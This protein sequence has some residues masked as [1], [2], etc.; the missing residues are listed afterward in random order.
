MKTRY[1]NFI[2]LLWFIVAA[3]TAARLAV[4]IL[5]YNTFDTFWYRDWA[6]GLQEGLFDIYTRAEQISLDYPPL[7]L[8]CLWLTGQA[9]RFFGLDCSNGMQMFLMKFWPIFFDMLCILFIYRICRRHGEW[10][11]I[12]AAAFWAFNPSVFYNTAY[13]GQT[14]QLMALLLLA[15]FVL[16]ERDRPIFACIIFAVAGLTKYQSLFFTPVLLPLIFKKYDLKRLLLGCGAAAA[17][18][19]AVFLPFMIGAREP[20]LFFKVYMGGANTYQYCTF[21]AYNLYSLLGLNTVLDSTP[22]FGSVT[23]AHIN[24]ILTLAV[25]AYT[26]FLMLC[27]KKPNPWV[28]G[29]FIMTAL[30]MLMTRMHER[31]Q[32]IVLP[33]ALMAFVTTKNRHFL[34]QTLL[35][36]ATSLLNQVAV[37]ANINGQWNFM[38]SIQ[39][40]FE[41]FIS[42]INLYILVYVAIICTKYLLPRKEQENDLQ[43]QEI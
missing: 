4:G 24:V 36:T 1:N 28:G 29:L 34:W 37:L 10:T 19:A 41:S 7:Y 17:T 9:Y 43:P 5:Y 2:K 22:L 8:F 14:D 20:F 18:V 32:F 42:V 31:Y 23:F 40:Y 16:A 33:F 27:S 25:I 13:W 12:F 15:A 30:F 38:L 35:L 21:N 11:A 26:V 6:I 39:P 3:A